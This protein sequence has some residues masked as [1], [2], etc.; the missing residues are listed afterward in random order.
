MAVPMKR[1]GRRPADEGRAVCDCLYSTVF[2][3][4][5]TV[6]PGALLPCFQGRFGVE[7]PCFRGRFTVFPGTVWSRKWSYHWTCGFP[8]LGTKGEKN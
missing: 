5:V 8:T 7:V 4:T 1:D 3:G 2:P 6:F